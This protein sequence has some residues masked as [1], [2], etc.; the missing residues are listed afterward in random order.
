MDR[1][2]YSSLFCKGKHYLFLSGLGFIY[3]ALLYKREDN[4]ISIQD[5]RIFKSDKFI[6]DKTIAPKKSKT[7]QY[8]DLIAAPE[9]W[10][11]SNGY[12]EIDP[13]SI[14]KKKFRK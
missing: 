4:C 14:K 6:E 13:E 3:E 1:S 12:E 9:H 11:L 8:L 10:L 5:S 7:F 2:T